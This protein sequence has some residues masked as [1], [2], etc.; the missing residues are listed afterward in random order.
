MKKYFMFLFLLAGV[1]QQVMAE[2]VS[3]SN[4]SDLIAFASRVNDGETTL[5]GILK[6]DINLTGESFTRIGNRT[7]KYAGAFDGQGHSVTLDMNITGTADSDKCQGL[8]G[9]VTGGA[10][11]SNVIVK[12]SITCRANCVAALVGETNGSGTVT[13][14][15]VS[16]EATV[17]GT[18]TYVGAFLGNNS[19]GNTKVV[20]TNSYNT[21]NITSGGVEF[22]VMGGWC[23]GTSTYTNVYN[24]GSV[25][26]P[27]NAT[28]GKFTRNNNRTCTKC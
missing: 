18:G 23:S 4:A 17:N 11:I 20:V 26:G 1:W 16:C 7:Y 19:G 10:S 27:S 8:F 28:G 3:I 5:N 9:C 12:G 14:T 6:A 25:T 21:G 22:S 15:N 24:T 13:I 2:D